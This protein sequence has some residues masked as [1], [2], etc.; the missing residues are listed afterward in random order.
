M[1]SRTR[2]GK[3]SWHAA[4]SPSRTAQYLHWPPDRRPKITPNMLDN[5]AEC[6]G[7]LAPDKRAQAERAR[8]RHREKGDEASGHSFQPKTWQAHIVTFAL[9]EMRSS[10][11]AFDRAVRSA[12]TRDD[13]P[14]ASLGCVRSMGRDQTRVAHVVTATVWCTHRATWLA[15]ICRMKFARRAC[16]WH[17]PH[18]MRRPVHQHQASP[19]L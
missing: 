9:M 12:A 10:R 4:V 19:I 18:S 1:D 15:I 8:G 16:F 7:R 2:R 3:A 17:R 6:R 5:C 14:T 13:V 11:R